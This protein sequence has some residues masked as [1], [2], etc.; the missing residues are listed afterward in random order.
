MN[1]CGQRKLFIRDISTMGRSVGRRAVR[2][3]VKDGPTNRRL[4]QV[5][6]EVLD[7]LRQRAAP[8]GY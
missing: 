1:A 5:F 3:A 7:E 8:R 4:V 6:R 2:I